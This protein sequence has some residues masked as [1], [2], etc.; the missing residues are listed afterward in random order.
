M[1]PAEN[2]S[3]PAILASNHHMALPMRRAPAYEI[4]PVSSVSLSG[5]IAGKENFTVGSTPGLQSP[6]PD[7]R[8]FS[9]ITNAPARGLGTPLSNDL[10]LRYPV[11]CQFSG[12]GEISVRTGRINSGAIE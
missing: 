9:L 12:E 6:G 8:D 10:S 2:H 4:W 1:S 3:Q 5:W 11:S 7:D